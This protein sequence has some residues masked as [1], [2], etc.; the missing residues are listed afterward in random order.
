MTPTTARIFKNPPLSLAI[1][2]EMK[3]SVL[4]GLQSDRHT[5]F[6]VK[7][8]KKDRRHGDPNIF[9][10]SSSFP[11]S[12]LVVER[13]ERENR[14]RTVSLQNF[15]NGDKYGSQWSILS[16]VSVLWC[17]L[18]GTYYHWLSFL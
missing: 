4:E 7:T 2:F 12:N 8:N 11:F 5:N 3:S 1:L 18:F 16:D 13:D 9:E 14:L 6:K 17:R 10:K 15:S